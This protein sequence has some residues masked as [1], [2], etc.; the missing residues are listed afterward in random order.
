MATNMVYKNEDQIPITLTSA[1][2]PTATA[3]AD[4]G[5]AVVL[6]QITGVALVDSESA[7]LVIRRKGVFDLEVTATDNSGNSAVAPG[8]AL[9]ID[10]S[11]GTINKNS[12]KVLFG[13]ALEAIDSGD[14]AT[15]QVLLK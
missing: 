13:Y 14:T 8:D 9:Y 5:D 3:G 15:I 7:K 6:G 10:S 12:T 4:S 11:N 1:S 2:W